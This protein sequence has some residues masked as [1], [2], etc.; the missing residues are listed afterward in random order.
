MN[1]TLPTVRV[2]ADNDH[3]FAVINESDFD[4]K[5]H[6]LFDADASAKKPPVAPL[7]ASKSTLH[8]K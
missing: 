3:G 7:H 6:T 1:E 2:K 4:P 5:K 8:K